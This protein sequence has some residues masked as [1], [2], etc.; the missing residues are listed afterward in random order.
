MSTKSVVYGLL[1]VATAILAIA[2]CSETSV[3]APEEAPYCGE[4]TEFE[5]V[6][7]FSEPQKG[8]FHTLTISQNEEDPCLFN[9]THLTTLNDSLFLRY[10]G[11]FILEK[12]TKRGPMLH[13]KYETLSLTFSRRLVGQ[14][15]ESQ[16]DAH[17]HPREEAKV[18]NDL[19]YLWSRQYKRQ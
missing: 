3:N 12:A 13:I 14:P 7:L 17:I 9:Y 5:G 8:L 11:L 1:L 6:W 10:T 18:W 19:L 4:A 2:S 15:W 16:D